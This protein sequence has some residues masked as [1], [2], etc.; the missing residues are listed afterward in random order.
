MVSPKEADKEGDR[1]RMLATY[2]AKSL[3]DPTPGTVNLNEPPSGI[4]PPPPPLATTSANMPR[5]TTL[6]EV[7][8]V[9]NT[10]QEATKQSRLLYVDLFQKARQKEESALDSALDSSLEPAPLPLQVQTARLDD[11][12]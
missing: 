3:G 1:D 8:R 7:K 5:M 12:E 2:P 6:V 10:L 9:Y 11:Q 4:L